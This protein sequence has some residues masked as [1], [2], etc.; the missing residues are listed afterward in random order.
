PRANGIILMT[1]FL[2]IIFGTVLAGGLKEVLVGD[3]GSARGLSGALA[4]CVGIA[5]AGT[6]TALVIR[7]LPAAQPALKYSADCWG[8]SREVSAM[9]RRDAT[10]LKALLISSVF[11][12]VSGLAVPTV[13]RL[14]L[15]LLNV[16]DT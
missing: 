14:G 10:L 15:E 4:V 11:W 8:V 12:L 6:L 16:G 2:A 5:V 9:L 13:N 3:D 1:T 7:R